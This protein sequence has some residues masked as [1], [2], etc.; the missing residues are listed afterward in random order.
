MHLKTCFL[1]LLVLFSCNKVSS[2][3][4]W[5]CTKQI[6]WDT[7]QVPTNQT[8]LSGV[9]SMLSLREPCCGLV[10]E[11]SGGSTSREGRATSPTARYS[12][13]KSPAAAVSLPCPS[14]VFNLIFLTPY[15]Q[16]NTTN[17][18]KQIPVQLLAE[19]KI[20]ESLFLI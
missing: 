13:S 12:S 3:L 9:A 15:K 20:T 5:P 6:Q 16:Q 4:E 8:S 19:K 14:A 2:E 10:H 1:Q 17:P 11:M 7:I 18:L